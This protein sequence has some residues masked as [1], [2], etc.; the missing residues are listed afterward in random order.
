MLTFNGIMSNRPA[1]KA[2]L[3]GPGSRMIAYSIL[4]LWIVAQPM[5]MRTGL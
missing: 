4:S 1:K 2:R 3:R 5:Q